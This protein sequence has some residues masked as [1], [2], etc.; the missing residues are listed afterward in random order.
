MSSKYNCEQVFE[1]ASKKTTLTAAPIICTII[2]GIL[3]I[4]LSAIQASIIIDSSANK[5]G[6]ESWKEACN[7][8]VLEY[9]SPFHFHEK[10]T[11]GF[12]FG[13]PWRT[14]NT[15]LRFV[16]VGFMIIVN[17]FAL[18]VLLSGKFEKSWPAIYWFNWIVFVM[19]FVAFVLDCDG[20][21]TGINACN[22]N[23]EVEEI[24]IIRN[25][26]TNTAIEVGKCYVNPWIYTL[27]VDF[28][29]SLVAFCSYKISRYYIFDPNERKQSI[30]RFT[31]A[32][33]NNNN[34][35]YTSNGN[36]NNNNNNDMMTTTT[37][38]EL[39]SGNNQK[40]EDSPD[41]FAEFDGG[42]D[43]ED[44]DNNNNNNN[45]TSMGGGGAYDGRMSAYDE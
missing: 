26:D 10:T 5:E 17:I 41:P 15:I 19:M 20:V 9:L 32:N 16:V 40:K 12:D 2:L 38:T 3:L 13:C 42:Y 35:S 39:A 44:N 25:L 30:G 7:N 31:Q 22:K 1:S 4:V 29:T 33:N 21:N 43:V 36:D 18:T 27:I 8:D 28:I 24:V 6:E 14:R 45:R 23:F 11:G 34:T 37:T